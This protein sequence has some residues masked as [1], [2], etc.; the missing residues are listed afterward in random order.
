MKKQ[1]RENAITLVVLIVTIVI[2]LI[3]AGITIATLSGE[4]G[5][6]EKDKKIIC[7]W[8]NLKTFQKKKQKKVKMRSRS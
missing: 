4:N 8:M 7:R 1:K 2:L 5:L 6:L 3:L